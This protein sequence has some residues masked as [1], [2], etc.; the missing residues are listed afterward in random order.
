MALWCISH[1]HLYP[2]RL[3]LTFK[4]PLWLDRK[5]MS[6]TKK[7]LSYKYFRIRLL[8]DPQKLPCWANFPNQSKN[9]FQIDGLFLSSR[10]D[11]IANKCCALIEGNDKSYWEFFSQPACF[12]CVNGCHCLSVEFG[13][14]HILLR[15]DRRLTRFR[16]RDRERESFHWSFC[17]ILL[18]STVKILSCAQ[19]KN[20]Q[21]EKINR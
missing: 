11:I 15:P 9:N 5:L 17:I 18:H 1:N 12:L 4:A 2:L 20:I 13:L 8:W 10:S 7:W 6:S 3:F 14:I 19:P 21:Q 16:L